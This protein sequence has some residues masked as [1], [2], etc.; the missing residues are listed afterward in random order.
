MSWLLD[1]PAVIGGMFKATG[2]VP[3]S[4]GGVET[5][6]H[7]EHSVVGLGQESGIA[8]SEPAVVIPAGILPGIGL[9][10]ETGRAEGIGKDITVGDYV[11]DVRAV[12]Q[13][14]A[15]G[16]IRIFLSNRRES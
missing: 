4:Y 16:E 15:P 9:D 7:F 8:A 10:D 5:H 6:G 13:G 3:V 14:S 12:E 11:W 2:G 1:D